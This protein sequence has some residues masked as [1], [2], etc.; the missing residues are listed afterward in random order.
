MS[1]R[2]PVIPVVNAL[3]LMVLHCHVITAQR[4]LSESPEACVSISCQQALC[5]E[6]VPTV[7]TQT[8]GVLLSKRQQRVRDVTSRGRCHTESKQISDGQ[9]PGIEYR[10]IV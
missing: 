7:R 9:L 6:L 4:V 10:L 1:C 5:V 2:S 3:A 8:Q